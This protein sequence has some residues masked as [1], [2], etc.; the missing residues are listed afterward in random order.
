M[1]EGRVSELED[2]IIEF[3]ESEQQE[4]TDWKKINRASGICVKMA[5]DPTFM[6]VPSQKQKRRG[7]AEKVLKE[8]IAKIPNLAKDINPQIKKAEW[9]PIG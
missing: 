7:G 9:T 5:T 2:R 3:I 4:K 1:T 8:V 6:S